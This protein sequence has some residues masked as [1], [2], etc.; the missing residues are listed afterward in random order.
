MLI[1]RFGSSRPMLSMTA[2]AVAGAAALA[3]MR[4]APD[5][6]VRPLLIMLTL[7]GAMIN[8]VAD[9]DVRAG[10]RVPDRNS[11]QWRG[12]CRGNRQAG[13]LP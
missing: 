1:T 9:N 6:D 3:I 7:T 4:I 11:C 8:A 2:A 12:H 10:A 13:R 5:S